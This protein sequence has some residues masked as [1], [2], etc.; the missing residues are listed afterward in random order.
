[1][2][3]NLPITTTEVPFPK[4]HYIVSRTDLKGSITYVNETFVKISGF[5]REELIGKNHNLVRHPDMLPGAFQWLWDTVKEGRPWRGIVKNRCKNGDFYWVDALVVPVLK[6]SEIIGYMSVR[7][8]PSKQ[9]IAQAEAFYQQLKDGQAS[10][11]KTVWWKRISLKVKLN[12]LVSLLL[13]MQIVGWVVYQSGSSI[14]FSPDAVRTL[15]QFFGIT[16]IAASIALLVGQS[17]VL[18]VIDRIVGRLDNIAQGDLTDDI[19]LTR[20]DEL[21]KLNNSLITMQTHIKAMMAEISESADLMGEGAQALSSEMENTR[22]VTLAQSDAVSRIAAAVEQLVASVNEIADSAQQATQAVEASHGLLGQ[23]SS[24]MGQSMAATANV[25]STVGDA[26][27]TMAELSQSILAIDRVSHVIRGI[28]DQTNLLALNAAIEAARAGEAGRGF[29]VVADE[30]R[31]LA[32]QSSRQTIEIATSVQEIQRVTQLVLGTMEAAGT[33][34]AST[35]VA[36]NSA[37]SGLDSVAHHGEEVA[38]ISRHISDGTRQQ[39]A[40]G[41]EIAGQV[42][43]IVAGIEKTTVAISAV[44]EKTVEM[45]AGASSL[46]QLI[47]Y[48]RFMR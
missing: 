35:D 44:T 34:V 3:T 33:H 10:L 40:A 8:A 30:V 42:E 37:R 14:G 41:N 36:M 25:V 28:A 26:S 24:S 6:A 17:Q 13:G 46:R 2:K 38:S 27:K 18:T 39:A 48:F 19:P 43:D 32:E 12:G 22:R 20:E 29:A 9:Q 7:T 4:G 16:G 47:A 21:G 31:K 23:A 1:M 45:K 15:L 5:T 11:P